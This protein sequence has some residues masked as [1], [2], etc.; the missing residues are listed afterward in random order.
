[1]S[2][3]DATDTR[4][5]RRRRSRPPLWLVEGLDIVDRHRSPLRLVVAGVILVAAVLAVTVPSLVPPVPLVGAAVAL[6]ALLLG[7][8]AVVAIDAADLTVR[9]PR[10]VRAAGGEL[11]AVLP[12][13]AEPDE[14]APLAEAVLDARDGERKLLL[15]LA[16]VAT[17]PQRAASWTDALGVALARRGVSVL[18]IDLASGASDGPGLVEVVRDGERLA[19]VVDFDPDLELARAGAGRDHAGALEAVRSLP[20]RLPRDLDVL[21]VALPAAADRAVVEASRAL[22]HVLVI[23]ERDRTSR[24]ELIA[25]LDALDAASIAA[26][27]ALLDDR[28]SARLGGPRPT[29][30]RTAETPW[31][32]R[33]P[34]TSEPPAP[35]AGAVVEEEPGPVGARDVEVVL[36]AEAA[37]FEPEPSDPEPEPS[38]PEPEPSDPEPP[39][40]QPRDVG[41]DPGAE[42]T[43]PV[44]AASRD[45][46]R[47]PASPDV[48]EELPAVA[49]RREA[50]AARSGDADALR[51]TAQLAA[52][53]GDLDARDL[54]A[55]ERDARERDVP[56]PIERREPDPGA[57]WP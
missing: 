20:T 52:L 12:R 17:D 25:A 14:A 9:G 31:A 39:D 5:T 21:L 13:S 47:S 38:D 24:V 11:V 41:R 55:R 46:S 50:V 45:P 42:T 7:L 18:D 8:A 40:P 44:P 1:M 26:Q 57:R 15:G 29:P 23:A 22:D 16:S 32:S 56:D 35:S 54:D 2:D 53:L 30:A 3:P 33:R 19:R 4:E 36:G 48:T 28:T 43:D 27:V 34:P 37:G 10:H 6:A 51:T 49:E